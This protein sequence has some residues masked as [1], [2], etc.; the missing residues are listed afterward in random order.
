MSWVLKV[1]LG[2]AV[3]N[4]GGSS[5]EPKLLSIQFII[6]LSTIYGSKEAPE[7][8]QERATCTEWTVWAIYPKDPAAEM[9]THLQSILLDKI[10]P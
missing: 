6:I 9:S 5:R 1:T 8:Y 7:I 2:S 3:T 4:T 10:F